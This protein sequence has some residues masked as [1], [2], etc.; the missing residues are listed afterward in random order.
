[1]DALVPLAALLR[2]R[3][4]QPHRLPQVQDVTRRDPRLGQ[5]ALLE[6]VTQVA[7]VGLVGVA[8]RFLPR[9]ALVS[10]GSARCGS[11]PARS[12]SSTTNRHPVVASTANAPS[13]AGSRFSHERNTSRVAGAIRPRP[14]SPLS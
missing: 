14:V 13:R 12:S 6:Q 11:N 7:S 3:V 10:A 8:R 9:A 5:T 4:P 2:Q 1:M